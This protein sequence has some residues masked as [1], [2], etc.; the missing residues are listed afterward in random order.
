MPKKI[1]ILYCKAGGGHESAAKAIKNRF[2]ELYPEESDFLLLDIYAGSS[3]FMQWLNSDFYGIL[4]DKLSPIW[5]ILSFL[6][7]YKWFADLSQKTSSKECY[8]YV[9]QTIADYQPDMVIS[10]YFLADV[11]VRQIISEFQELEFSSLEIQQSQ[12]QDSFSNQQTQNLSKNLSE[13]TANSDI[14]DNNTEEIARPKDWSKVITY[15]LVTELFLAP[16]MWFFWGGNFLTFSDKAT[17]IAKQIS[18]PDKIFKIKTSTGKI[19]DYQ[20]SVTQFGPFFNQKPSLDSLERLKKQ[21]SEIKDISQN[22]SSKNPISESSQI[23]NSNEL[24]NIMLVG[25]GSGIPGGVKILKNLLEINKLNLFVVCGR[26][27]NIYNQILQY[28]ENI[29]FETA[30]HNVQNNQMIDSD[31][32]LLTNPKTTQ[33]IYLWGFCKSIKTVINLSDMVISKSGP[34]LV[35]EVLSQEKPLFLSHYIWEHEKGNKE[36]VVKNK[37]GE[38]IPN[39]KKMAQRLA[40]ITPSE[41][42]EYT[43]N[44]Q[45]SIQAGVIKSDIDSLINFLHNS[46]TLK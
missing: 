2:S 46:N 37:F 11:W 16:N 8:D 34:A 6:W 36:F 38:Y 35:M 43:K 17:A 23:N 40:S 10:T 42:Q 30:R 14:K 1:L 25:G 13:K 4:V 32:V 39:P 31:F 24:K 45:K 20:F 9:K 44:I 5:N 3:S 22:L 33:N 21:L 12:P 15:N 28:L 19:L 26:D 29:G 41:L 7:R 27:K 18:A